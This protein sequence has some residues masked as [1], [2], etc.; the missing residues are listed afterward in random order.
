MVGGG[1]WM[2][3]GGWWM[4]DGGWW[5]VDGGWWMV[6]SGWLEGNTLQARMLSLDT[7]YQ[8]SGSR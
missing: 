2:V 3:D 1:W 6:D 8:L 4:V 7:E 5:M